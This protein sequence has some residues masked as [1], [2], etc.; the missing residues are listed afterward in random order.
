MK[1]RLSQICSGDLVIFYEDIM[2][3]QDSIENVF[4]NNQLYEV[5][6]S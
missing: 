1:K 6:S 2:F 3:D 5:I 4:I